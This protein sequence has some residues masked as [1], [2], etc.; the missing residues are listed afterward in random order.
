MG[1]H[2]KAD[3]FHAIEDPAAIPY[4]S[5]DHLA[6]L[7]D[8][9]FGC[10]GRVDGEVLQ[11]VGSFQVGVAADPHVF[12]DLTVFDDGAVSD[13]AIISPTVIKFFFR[14]FLELVL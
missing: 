13:L 2:D 1:S 12:D 9:G 14:E 6:S 3:G 10:R 11:L 4:D 5:V 8:L 7:S